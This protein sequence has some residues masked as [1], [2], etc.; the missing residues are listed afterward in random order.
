[1]LYTAK[2]LATYNRFVEAE[3]HEVKD[4]LIEE[5]PIIL[6]HDYKLQVS[7]LKTANKNKETIYFNKNEEIIFSFSSTNAS[8]FIPEDVI[9]NGNPYKVTRKTG[10]DKYTVTLVG[11]DVSGKQEI[12]IEKSDFIKWS[13][14][15]TF[16]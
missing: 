2:V 8:I 7:N 14:I 11:Y 5:I 3:D 16:R 10:T 1:M 6:V 9:I 13:S 15:R 12:K 4:Q